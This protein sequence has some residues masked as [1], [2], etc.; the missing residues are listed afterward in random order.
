M[1]EKSS[2]RKVNLMGASS[3]VE[4]SRISCECGKGEFVF[5]VCEADRWLY[6]GNPREK[7][8][9]LHIYCEP[10][11]GLFPQNQMTKFSENDEKTRWKLI[12][13]VADQVP[14]H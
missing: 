2:K 8:F 11:A 9:E 7:W 4:T 12:I 10:C 14:I 3:R 6:A 13:P 1:A 5:Y